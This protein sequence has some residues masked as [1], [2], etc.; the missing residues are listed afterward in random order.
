MNR[1][2]D[3]TV[4]EEPMA[5]APM[6]PPNRN[7]LPYTELYATIRP[8]LF[9]RS[10]RTDSTK[11]IRQIIATLT[12]IFH[13]ARLNGSHIEWNYVIAY[14]EA[15]MDKE[16]TALW[17]WQIADVA[18]T[19]MEL[20]KFLRKRLQMLAEVEA[21]ASGVAGCGVRSTASREQP[22]VWKRP[23]KPKAVRPTLAVAERGRFAPVE[24]PAPD[25][26][27]VAMI[28]QLHAMVKQHTEQ[29]QTQ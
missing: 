11:H 15:M 25:E 9:L 3:L 4:K 8:L 7:E 18:P 14:I 20:L 6:D 26:T 27:L 19:S 5:A 1:T 28:K 13:K 22:P 12:G 2:I 10:M 16:T 29:S 21:G 17:R 23:V 24:R